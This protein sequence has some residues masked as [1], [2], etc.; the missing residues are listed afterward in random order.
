MKKNIL[1][2]V[3]CVFL[4]S[5]CASIFNGSTQKIVIQTEPR[6][7]EIQ[8]STSEG[9]VIASGMGSL[10]YEVKRS[11]GYFKGANYILTISAPG[12]QSQHIDLQSRLSGWY[13]G[14]NIFSGGLIGWLVIDPISGGMW[15]IDA[16]NAQ[17]TE[18][19]K[20]TLLK[21][22]PSQVMVRARRIR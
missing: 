20:V 5:G 21:D 13:L 22:T 12:Y 18:H 19:L 17:D 2:F 4:L 10:T 8:L 16:S 9:Q 1:L 7:A 3:F 6:T 15:V 14:G 11:R